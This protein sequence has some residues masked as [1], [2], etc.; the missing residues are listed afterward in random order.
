MLMELKCAALYDMVGIGASTLDV[1]TV[2]KEFPIKRQVEKAVVTKCCG[3]GPVAAAVAT[4]AMLGSHVAMVDRLGDDWAGNAV[5]SKF[6]NAGVDTAAGIERIAGAT[7]SVSTI[8]IKEATGERAIFFQPGTVGEY[9]SIEA[10][11]QII[12][13]ARILHINGRH[14]KAL[15]A[16]VAC[17]HRNGTAVS[18]DGGADRY[19]A[20]SAAIAAKADI[21][22]VALDF[23]TK[24]T[25]RSDPEEACRAMLSTGAA[26]VGV[27]AGASGSWIGSAGVVFHQPAVRYK[28]VVDTTG[29]GDS[30][31]GAFLHALASGYTLRSCALIASAVAAM[32]ASALGGRGF[33]PTFAELESFIEDNNLGTLEKK[34]APC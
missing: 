15:D 1:L 17:A 11:E 20:A 21:C 34:E 14:S 30:Y 10:F 13:E 8:L 32:N 29:C 7:S 5:V 9:D 2:V 12:K 25:G 31:H 23:A 19:N 28:A 22:I 18:F 3:G 33:L 24:M 6:R 16:A 26:V 4:C 27:T